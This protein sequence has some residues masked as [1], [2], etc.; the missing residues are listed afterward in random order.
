VAENGELICKQGIFKNLEGS[1]CEATE[2]LYHY[3]LR[4]LGGGGQVSVLIKVAITSVRVT[5]VLVEIRIG[6]LT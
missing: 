6:L 3:F 4:E 2:L 1:V 5:S